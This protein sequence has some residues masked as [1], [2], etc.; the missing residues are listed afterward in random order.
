MRQA[1]FKFEQSVITII[2][3]KYTYKVEGKSYAQAEA[4]IKEAF[5]KKSEKGNILNPFKRFLSKVAITDSIL[6]KPEM[7][8]KST[9]SIEYI[10]SKKTGI[11]PKQLYNNVDT[12]WNHF[13]EIIDEDILIDN[14][15]IK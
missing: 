12:T 4:K 11:S 7:L 13:D 9:L 5:D 8:G 10:P 14:K 6:A 2:E 3:T 15:E 1:K